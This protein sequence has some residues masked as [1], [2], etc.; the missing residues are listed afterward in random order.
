MHVLL[1]QENV[2]IKGAAA[3]KGELKCR[4]LLV[5]TTP[6]SKSQDFL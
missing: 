5:N 4:L 2:G 6:Q 3:G 1:L